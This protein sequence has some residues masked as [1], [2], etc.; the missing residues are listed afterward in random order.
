MDIMQSS[1]TYI[2]LQSGHLQLANTST[3]LYL[4]V[5][6]EARCVRCPQ[7]CYAE[8]PQHD[9]GLREVLCSTPFLHACGRSKMTV[10]QSDMTVMLYWSQNDRRED[11]W[12]YDSLLP[13]LYILPE[14]WQAT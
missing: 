2:P 1:L 7:A 12:I 8:T 10:R 11:Q 14:D 6:V 4:I 5:L 3:M 9:Q 13:R